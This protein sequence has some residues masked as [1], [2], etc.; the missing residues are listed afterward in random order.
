MANR[1]GTSINSILQSR[2]LLYI[3]VLISTI[4]LVGYIQINDGESFTFFI[5]VGYLTSL[6]SKNMSVVL[7]SA[8]F[9]TYLF[10]R[11]H[12]MFIEGLENKNDK[13]DKND[14]SDDQQ[15]GMQ[16]LK[17][18]E[19][20]TSDNVKTVSG[21]DKKKPKLNAA[22]TQVA[23]MNDLSSSIDTKGIERMTKETMDLMQA[24]ETMMNKV[25]S[26]APR[27]QGMIK[28]MGGM[29]GIEKMMNTVQSNQ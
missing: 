27:V 21:G 25:E 26:M 2:Y 14:K 9:F 17:P 19:L 5:L 7:I 13:N 18:T 8:I 24:Q 16:N 12:Q 29:K 10:N 4:N 6:F 3:L 20:D 23:F 22:E 15:D 28:Q 11:K 1:G